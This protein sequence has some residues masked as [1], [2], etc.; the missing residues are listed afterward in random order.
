MAR[1]YFDLVIVKLNG[2][3]SDYLAALG[4]LPELNPEAKL[5]IMGEETRFPVEAFEIK[6]DDYIFMPCRPV[7]VW[8]RIMSCLEASGPTSRSAAAVQG[9]A[10]AINGRIVNKL[11]L[12][13]HD[14]RGGLVSIG[15]AIQHIERQAQGKLGPD[16]DNLLE[17]AHKKAGQLEGLLEE[18]LRHT[19]FSEDNPEAPGPC[20][21]RE[22]VVEP[23]LAELQEDLHRNHI[24]IENRLNLLPPHLGMIKGD[25]LTLQNIFR[26]LMGNAIS[27]GGR[28]C[29]LRLDYGEEDPYLRL[30]VYNT[31]AVITGSVRRALCTRP[32]AMGKK[33]GDS[34]GLGLKLHL[35]RQLLQSYGGDIRYECRGDSS[36]FHVILPM[37]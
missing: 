14:L 12:L 35:T 26:N 33:N 15:S 7:E 18:F 30:K 16:V 25:R 31:G 3:Q 22:D 17:D 20:N 29:T 5:I 24:T 10:K 19:V 2:R 1:K 8:R 9:K 36:N 11:G 4:M 6:A 32:L 21:L 27:Y 37:H 23:V 28:G 34:P 13:F